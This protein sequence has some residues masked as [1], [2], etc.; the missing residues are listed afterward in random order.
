M[1]KFLKVTRGFWK[2]HREPYAVTILSKKSTET[3][4]LPRGKDSVIGLLKLLRLSR[5][6]LIQ[7]PLHRFLGQN[8]L[9]VLSSPLTLLLVLLYFYLC[10]AL[11]DLCL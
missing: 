9:M 8:L 10:E 11:F 3:N 1:S 4:V 5:T 2:R 6:E 7:T